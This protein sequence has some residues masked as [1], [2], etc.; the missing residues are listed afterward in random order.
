[1]SA[2]VEQHE[3][4]RARANEVRA[5]RSAERRALRQAGYRRARPQMAALL[6][7]PPDWLWNVPIHVAL[8]WLPGVGPH[9]VPRLLS[10]ADVQSIRTVSQLTARQRLV[11]AGALS[12]ERE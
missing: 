8:M 2:T 4:A 7:N 1:M 10:L 3:I 5:A 12:G 11:L 9:A 6:T